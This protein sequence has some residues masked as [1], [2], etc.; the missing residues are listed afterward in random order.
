MR[1][2][3]TVTIPDFKV[4]SRKS[5]AISVELTRGVIQRAEVKV[6]DTGKILHEIGLAFGIHKKK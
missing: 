2:F 4:N 3:S 5:G 1:G 6:A